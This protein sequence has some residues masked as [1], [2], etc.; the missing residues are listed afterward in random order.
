MYITILCFFILFKIKFFTITA[1]LLPLSGVL[2]LPI[3]DS[4]PISIIKDK[5]TTGTKLL[6][7]KG[8]EYKF[9]YY[10]KGTYYKGN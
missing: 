2:A 6:I 4:S 1:L 9:D 7:Y 3:T 10:K 5:Y 8:Q